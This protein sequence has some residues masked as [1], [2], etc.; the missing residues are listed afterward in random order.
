[1]SLILKVHC[2]DCNKDSLL[3]NDGETVVL[4]PMCG[5]A[6]VT[7]EVVEDEKFDDPNATVDVITI[8]ETGEF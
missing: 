6:N 7:S 4:C 8:T 5:S 1:M 2:S 3:S